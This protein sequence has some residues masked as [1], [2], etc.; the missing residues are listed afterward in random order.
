MMKDAPLP[1]MYTLADVAK[2][3]D[4][5]PQRVSQLVQDGELPSRKHGRRSYVFV[6]DDL[7]P[8]LKRRRII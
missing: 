1:K 2:L 8:L 7:A 4:R 3:L 5:T 6:F